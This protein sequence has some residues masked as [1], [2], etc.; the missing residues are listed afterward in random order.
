M[1]PSMHFISTPGR[2][3]SSQ[4][5]LSRAQEFTMFQRSAM[6]CTSARQHANKLDPSGWKCTRTLACCRLVCFQPA[7]Y[8]SCLDVPRWLETAASLQYHGAN[9]G[10]FRRLSL[11]L[12]H[13]LSLEFVRAP[14]RSHHYEVMPRTPATDGLRLL[15]AAVT[16]RSWRH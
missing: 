11:S 13:F 9:L 8:V 15:Q 2:L 6:P 3:R 14:V 16:K 5:R 4:K 1:K 7:W 10:S 12:P